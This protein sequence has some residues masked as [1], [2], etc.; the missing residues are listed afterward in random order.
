MVYQVLTY[1][2]LFTTCLSLFFMFKFGR[3][4]IKIEDNLETAVDRLDN[5][6]QTIT[7]ILEI[8]VF[9]DSIEIKS[10]LNEIERSRDTI[11]NVANNIARTN[12]DNE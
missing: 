8:P 11:I 7:D 2:F 9:Y 5:S 12:E 6:Q 4:L 1:V 10:V 3:I